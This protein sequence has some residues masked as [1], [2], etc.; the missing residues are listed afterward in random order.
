MVLKQAPRARNQLKRVAK[1]T[2]TMADGDYLEKCWLLLGD[3]Y[4][5]SGKYDMATELLKRC[6][7]HNR[8]CCK[9]FEYLGYIMEKEQAYKDAAANYE[10]AWKT[11]NSSNPQVGSSTSEFLVAYTRLYKSLCQTVH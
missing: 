7:Q 10:S 6:V 11:S 4:I 5:Q 3:I 2:W 1:A 8:S 9:A